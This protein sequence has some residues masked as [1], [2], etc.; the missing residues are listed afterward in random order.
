MFLPRR[1]REIARQAHEPVSRRRAA[2]VELGRG[3]PHA[4]KH[5]REHLLGAF[6]SAEELHDERKE[7]RSVRVV[8]RRK[9]SLVASSDLCEKRGVFVPSGC[10][11]RGSVPRVGY[12]RHPNGG[13]PFLINA[14]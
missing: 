4:P 5:F 9:R 11:H 14:W 12:S 1:E 13:G 6:A 7:V 10:L 3:E 8:E 2:R